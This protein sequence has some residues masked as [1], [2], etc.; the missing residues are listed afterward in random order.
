KKERIYRLIE[1]QNRISSELNKE[2]IGKSVE[3]LVEGPSKT[4]PHKWTGKTRTN[5]TINFV[6]P[7]NLVG[8]TVLVTVTDGKLSS[9]EGDM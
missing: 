1:V 8:Q 3:V 9:L 5:K 2:L 6:G 7:K 4:D